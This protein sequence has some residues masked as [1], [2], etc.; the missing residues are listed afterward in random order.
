MLSVGTLAKN[1]DNHSGSH[2]LVLRERGRPHAWNDFKPLTMY[3][4]LPGNLF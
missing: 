3:T 4:L 2:S 1:S